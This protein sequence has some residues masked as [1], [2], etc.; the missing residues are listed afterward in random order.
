MG[1]DK[2]DIREY[3]RLHVAKSCLLDTD[4]D[5]S[6]EEVCSFDRKLPL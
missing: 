6:G 4:D 5:L 3:L 1:L 2:R